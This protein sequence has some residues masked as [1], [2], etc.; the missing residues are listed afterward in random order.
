M[1]KRRIGCSALE[2]EPL[3]LGTNVIGWTIDKATAFAV[4]DAFV[5]QGFTALD[6][7]DSYSRLNPGNSDSERI[8]G[9]WL[10]QRGNRHRLHIFTKVGSD[11]GQGRIDLSAAWIE[12]AVENSLRRLQTDYIDLYQSHFPDPLTPQEETLRAYDRLLRAGKVRVIGASNYAPDQLSEALVISKENHLSRYEA[13]QVAYNLCNRENVETEMQPLVS[14]KGISILAYYAL[15]S[16][17]LTGK[18][19]TNADFERSPRGIGARQYYTPVNM[20]KL[21]ALDEIAKA[22]GASPGE[23][24]LAWLRDR[25]SVGGMIASATS[26]S[27]VMSLANGV[28]LRLSQEHIDLLSR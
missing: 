10:A 14:A 22:T 27:Q 28:R 12:Q 19:R 21:N 3:L 5:D 23:I 18:Y 6:T 20:R 24:A 1:T 13:V 2:I 26:V 11:I 25:P 17:F 8:I 15:A 16:G 7:S 4:L 9:Q